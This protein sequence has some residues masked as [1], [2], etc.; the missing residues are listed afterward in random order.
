GGRPRGRRVVTT[1]HAPGV[2]NSSQPTPGPAGPTRARPLLGPGGGTAAKWRDFPAPPRTL[3][4]DIA[5]AVYTLGLPRQAPGG[6]R[7][8]GGRGNADGPG[9]GIREGY[10]R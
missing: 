3:P 2:T 5:P 8:R 4:C 6:A 1:C 10:S 9:P 7:A